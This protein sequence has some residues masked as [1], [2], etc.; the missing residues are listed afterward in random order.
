MLLLAMLARLLQMRDR[1]DLAPGGPAMFT[2]GT[3]GAPVFAYLHL[4]KE[5]R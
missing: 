2:V 1:A 5:D 4:T 3:L